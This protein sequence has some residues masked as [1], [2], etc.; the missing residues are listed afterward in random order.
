MATKP[1]IP[2]LPPY[3][4]GQRYLQPD[5]RPKISRQGVDL[6]SY[7]EDQLL[8]LRAEIDE[9]LPA[10]RLKDINLEEELVR[11]LAVAQ[12]LQRDV[13]RDDDF[14]GDGT[15]ANQKAQ[16]LNSVASALAVL[17]KLQVELYSSERLKRAESVMIET[18][19]NLPKEQQVVFLDLY[20]A[21]LGKL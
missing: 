15:P 20:E 14:E 13:L 3:N 4:A 6:D 17:G 8:E 11:Q 10:K 21:N 2:D 1:T 18:I 5:L 16:V 9:L 19:S 12:K 7:D